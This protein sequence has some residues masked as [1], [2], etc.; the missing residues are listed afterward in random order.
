MSVLAW[1]GVRKVR[2]EAERNV[3]PVVV[4]GPRLASRRVDGEFDATVLDCLDQSATIGPLL[5]W[6][7][8]MR[9]DEPAKRLVPLRP[10][11]S[12]PGAPRC[13]L[14]TPLQLGQ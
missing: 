6:E 10:M 11:T 14:S 4:A 13:T 5:H 7:C 9:R 2:G 8:L 12:C 1:S 3:H